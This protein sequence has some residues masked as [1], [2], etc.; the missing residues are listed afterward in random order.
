MLVLDGCPAFT[1]GISLDY[2]ILE[3]K[4]ALFIF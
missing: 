3:R 1:L 4:F 2:I